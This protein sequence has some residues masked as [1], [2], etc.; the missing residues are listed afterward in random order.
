MV[1]FL[2]FRARQCNFFKHF[3]SRHFCAFPQVLIWLQVKLFSE[4]LNLTS[5]ANIMSVIKNTNS[6]PQYDK[7]LEDDGNEKEMMD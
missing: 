3:I 7:E 2:R 4:L 1:R 5:S 6:R